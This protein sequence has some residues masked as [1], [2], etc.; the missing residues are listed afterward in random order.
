LCDTTEFSRAITQGS[1]GPQEFS[2]RVVFGNF[3]RIP[4]RRSVEVPARVAHNLNL[5][6]KEQIIVNAAKG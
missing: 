2:G 4:H 6:V 1:N 5:I 3:A